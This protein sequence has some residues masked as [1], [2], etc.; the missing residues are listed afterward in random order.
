MFNGTGLV[1]QICILLIDFEACTFYG[2]GL[3]KQVHFCGSGLVK[4]VHFCGED[5]LKQVHN[6]ADDLVKQVHYI[7]L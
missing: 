4:Q 7:W 6:F 3:L 5:L 1:K 2:N